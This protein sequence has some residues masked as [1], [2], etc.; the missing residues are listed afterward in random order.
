MNNQFDQVNWYV[1]Y[2]AQ[3]YKGDIVSYEA[4]LRYGPNTLVFPHARFENLSFIEQQILTKS[5]VTDVCKLIK[6]TNVP[7]AFNL[8]STLFDQDFVQ[9]IIDLF[10]TSSIP[11]NFLRC[12]IVE[13][14]LLN[15]S[16]ISFLKKFQEVGITL[17]IDDLIKSNSEA[18]FAFFREHNLPCIIKVE[19]TS[20]VQDFMDTYRSQGYVII[21][22]GPNADLESDD[23][24]QSNKMSTPVRLK[25]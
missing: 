12:E 5:V 7:I 13:D 15:I 6:K 18:N 24:I 22:E 1:M 2:Q 20:E 9:D 16:H 14:E 3:W 19:T 21:Q 8:S 17:V 10:I 23:I 4:L 11:S 25:V